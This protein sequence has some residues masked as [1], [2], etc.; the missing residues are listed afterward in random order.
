MGCTSS[1]Q[2][3]DNA[4]KTM[5]QKRFAPGK[6]ADEMT[7]VAD[8]K[9]DPNDKRTLKDCHDD[10]VIGAVNSSSDES[11]S[12]NA[13]KP[14]KVE[15]PSGD[16]IPTRS[17]WRVFG[18]EGG[19]RWTVRVLEGTCGHELYGGR[20]PWGRTIDEGAGERTRQSVR[21]SCAEGYQEDG[22]QVKGGG[23]TETWWGW[24]V[25]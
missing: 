21:N 11:K 23:C 2:A 20:G 25:V 15:C 3:K 12:G 19:R 6:N 13:W 1:V 5:F 18:L 14:V 16:A 24:V 8:L 17:A 10:K 7:L 22:P 9:I 4:D